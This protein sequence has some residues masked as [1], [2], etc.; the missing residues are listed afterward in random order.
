MLRYL[1]RTFLVLLII[2]GVAVAAF[3]VRNPERTTLDATS[4]ATASGRFVTLTDG[5]THYDITGPDTGRAVILV[6]GSS[7]PY[8]IWDSTAVALGAA[9]Y[10][11]VRYDRFGIG[12]SDR[13][14]AAYDSTMF[15]RQLDELADSLKLPTF[16]LMGLSFGGFVTAHYVIAHPSRVRT[17]TLLDPGT[18]AGIIP[19]YLKLPLVG[20]WVTQTF[21]VPNAADG[22][23]GDFLHPELFPGWADRY[24]PQTMYRGLGRAMLRVG[25]ASSGTDYAA[26]YSAVGQAGIPVLL[27]WG[28]Q[29][30]VVPF[31]T[32]EMV[33][34]AIPQAEFVAVDSAGHLPATEQ[35]V[36]V[37]GKIKQFLD[38]H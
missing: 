15:T 35:S 38:K 26:L 34:T 31:A 24:R 6:H 32:S 28:R 37:H 9:G 1:R 22:Q 36:L 12:L 11:V 21:V 4:R 2:M 25:I 3:V 30:P 23:P 18:V 33:R 16:D 27:I 10:R 29:D 17:L 7:V 8:Y 19:A 14:D 13:P 5:V 20:T